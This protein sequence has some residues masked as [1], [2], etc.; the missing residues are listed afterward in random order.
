MSREFSS[1]LALE[2]S[3]IGVCYKLYSEKVFSLKEAV[4]GSVKKLAAGNF[5]KTYEELWALKDLSFKLK[6]GACLGLTGAN[7]SG[8]STALKVISGVLHPTEGEYWV[9]GRISALVELGA[10]FDIELTGREN[11]YLGASVAGLTRKE[12]EKRIDGI[13]DFSELGHFIDIPVK[14]YS[15]GMYARLGFSLATDIDP[16]VLIVDEILAVGD[17]PFQKKCFERMNQFRANGKTI[18][19]V[20][21]DSA[22]IK[23]F[24]TEVIRLDHGRIVE[25]A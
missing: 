17:E 20:S 11:I 7:G 13:I 3:G 15:S 25:R 19:F 1:D 8:K 10:G 18:I 9:R 24:C 4:I 21:H 16:D 23:T 2:V 12:V 6:R 22:T 5:R 14:N